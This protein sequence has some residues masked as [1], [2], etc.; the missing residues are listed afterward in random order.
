MYFKFAI[1]VHP[2]KKNGP[3]TIWCFNKFAQAVPRRTVATAMEVYNGGG[4][5][6]N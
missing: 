2:S 4:M 5:S 6:I 3:N 1:A